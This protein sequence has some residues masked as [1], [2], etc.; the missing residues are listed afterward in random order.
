M[1][2][3][4]HHST[5]P[6]P[7]GNFGLPII[8]E[9]LEFFRNPQFAKQRHQK[10]GEVFK[11]H[12]FGNPTVFLMGAEAN[13][14]LFTNEN[15][16]FNSTWPKSTKQLL[17]S[18]SLSVQQGGE[19]QKRRKVLAQAFQ[20][21]ALSS[22]IATIESISHE[23]FQ[24]WQKLQ[25][26]AWYPELKNYT[27][28]IACKLFVGTDGG[29]Q[30]QLGQDYEIFVNGL[31]S[32]PINLPGTR[33]GQ[34]FQGRKRLLAA[35]EKIIHQRQQQTQNSDSIEHRDALSLLINA[36]DEEG[37]NL[38]IDELK[39]Q[40]VTLLFAGHETL[41]S[42]LVSFCLQTAQYPEIFAKIYQ[43][44]KN[45]GFDQP[46]TLETLSQM[47]YLD[48]VLK[49]TMRLIPPVGG[50]FRQVVETCEFKGY[51]IPQGW[52]I[53]YQIGFTHQDDRI[54][55]QPEKFDPDRFSP[56]RAEDKNQLFSYIP[57]AGGMRECIGKE[58]AKLEMKI[59]AALLIRNYQWQ[60]LPEQDLGYVMIPTPRPRDGLK[61]R[62][63]SL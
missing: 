47:T 25:D 51:Q 37:N 60:I 59:F 57:F 16:Y 1:N 24:R 26:F 35:I 45:L 40:I 52:T 23:Y 49:E 46:L 5:L 17:G 19:H 30:T 20:P 9:T 50:G 14:F 58:F 18:C 41:T 56:E 8:G 22:Y 62:F 21:R 54:Y 15:K 31:F 27:L 3:N 2:T 61:V 12:L 7:P 32:I 63:F 6:L 36:K 28:D 34:A 43:E 39:D 33:F 42:A 44:Q 48:Q 55:S 11:T 10:Y 4:S 29:S 53:L 38:S 13:K